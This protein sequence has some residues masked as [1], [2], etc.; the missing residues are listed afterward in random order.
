MF[1]RIVDTRSD[2]SSDRAKPMLD[3]YLA[4]NLAG[5]T[6]GSDLRSTGHR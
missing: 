4:G 3:V 2:P 5:A 1:V 6:Y